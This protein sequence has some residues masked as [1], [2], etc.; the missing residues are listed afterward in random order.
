MARR[1]IA[2]S[3][4]FSQ[5]YNSLLSTATPSAWCVLANRSAALTLSIQ[6]PFLPNPSAFA[7]L[8]L[9]RTTQPMSRAW[10]WTLHET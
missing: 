1:G 5:V 7:F 9:S 3:E 6:K 2:N 10:V 8:A 4:C